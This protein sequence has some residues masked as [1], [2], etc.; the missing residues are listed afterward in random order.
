MLPDQQSMAGKFVPVTP[1]RLLDTRDGTGAHG[2]SAPLAPGSS[3]PLDVSGIT[4]N[5]SV[6]PT[7]VVLNVTV[8][9]GTAD[10]FVSVA[11]TNFVPSVSSVNFRAGQTV[12]NL[13]T[14]PLYGDSTVYFFNHAGNVDVIADVFGYYTVDQPGSSLTTLPPTRILDTREGIGAIGPGGT[15]PLPVTGRNSVPATGVTAVQL[16]VTVTNPTAGSFLSV[17]PS[18][19]APPN[20]SNLNFGPGQT[21]ANSVIVPVGPDGKIDFFNLAGRVDVVADISG[22]YTGNAAGTLAHGGVYE[23]LDAPTRLLDTRSDGGPVGAGQS[24][25]LTVKDLNTMQT[26]TPTAVVLNVTVTNPTASSFVTAYPNGSAVPTASNINF[27]SGQTLSNL[28]V[29][30]VGPDGKV[31]FFN[32]FGNVDLVVDMFG[33]FQAG[34]DLG[35]ESLAFAQSTVDATANGGIAVDVNWTVTDANPNASTVAGGIVLRR[36]G[37]QPNTYVGQSVSESFSPGGCCGMAT[38]VSGDA[39]RS[40]YTYRLYVPSLSDSTTTHWVVAAVNLSDDLGNHLLAAGSDLAGYPGAVLTATTNVGSTAPTYQR[41]EYGTVYDRP[42]LYDGATNLAVYHIDP[43]DQ[44]EDFWQGSLTVAG[45]GGQ[46]L[47][48][49][50][51][52]AQANGQ[53]LSYPCQD[54]G[55]EDDC[56]VAVLF[57]KG[58]AVGTWVV[59]K[60]SLTSDAGTTAVYDN[61]NAA[62]ITVGDNNSFYASGFSL[63]PTSVNNWRSDVDLT[64]SMRVTGARQGVSTIYADVDVN[65]NHCPTLSSTPTANPDGSYS[66]PVRMYKGTQQCGVRNIAVVD[67]AGDVALYGPL[68]AALDPGVAANRVP[69]TTPPSVSSVSVSPASVP[70]SKLSSTWITVT[71]HAAIGMA[72]IDGYDSYVYDSTGKVVGQSSGGTGQAVDGTVSLSVYPQT[73]PPGVYTIGFRLDDAGNLSTSYG[74]PGGNPMPGGPLTLTVTEG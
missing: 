36:A 2:R 73:V 59:S 62:P 53:H 22:Y 40:S 37:S 15:L 72:P 6:I 43:Q 28:V 34:P 32:R 26:G 56:T 71:A 20:V 50:F 42:Y 35:I 64:L 66:I 10:S 68:F 21:I 69:D 65:A 13:V 16:N 63:T 51:G 44:A 14:A 60:V 27:V 39:H 3:L 48:K 9:N 19:G 54:F 47:T 5:P 61:L 74:T 52:Q 31:A 41:V 11:A 57:P 55:H 58:T 4:G 17:F 46:T 70:A 24:R 30:P 18:G 12:P 49:T 25:A 8:T 29:V 38:F 23:T 33:Y 1:K 67:G 7:A 45:P